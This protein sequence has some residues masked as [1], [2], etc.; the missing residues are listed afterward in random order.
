MLINVYCDYSQMT[1]HAM[2][3][4]VQDVEQIENIKVIK[5]I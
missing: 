5:F 2:R 4:S 3:Y 1:S